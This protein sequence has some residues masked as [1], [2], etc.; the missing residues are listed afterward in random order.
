MREGR[1]IR[2]IR[3]AVWRGDLTEPFDAR[4]VN[5]AVGITWAGTFLPKHRFGNPNDATELFVRVSD[6]PA[7]YRLNNLPAVGK[8]SIRVTLG[9]ETAPGEEVVFFETVATAPRYELAPLYPQPSWWHEVLSPIWYREG[10]VM[11]DMDRMETWACYL[12]SLD[13]YP[14]LAFKSEDETLRV[15]HVDL[16]TAG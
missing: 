6:K 3:E 13:G 16:N 1:T 2:R 4:R 8:K 11:V 10:A 15:Y 12:F 9:R 7:L 5:D 14:M